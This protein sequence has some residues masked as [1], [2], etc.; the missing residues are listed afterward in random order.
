MDQPP[1]LPRESFIK[2][3]MRLGIVSQTI[4]SRRDLAAFYIGLS[5]S[6]PLQLPKQWHLPHYRIS[7][8]L[9]A[10]TAR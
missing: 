7:E 6:T 5:Y 1:R 2:H 8:L 10:F 4:A 3:E 9:R